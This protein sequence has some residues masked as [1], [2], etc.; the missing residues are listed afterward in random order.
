MW[1][2][3]TWRMK[4]KVL[5]MAWM[6]KY[7]HCVG[8]MPRS[9]A[10]RLAVVTEAIEGGQSRRMNSCAR[11]EVAMACFRTA[12]YCGRVATSW[13]AASIPAPEG[14][15]SSP[16]TA[17]CWLRAASDA[18]PSSRSAA[19]L[20]IWRGDS[21]RPAVRLAEGSRS[22]NRVGCPCA[23]SAAPSAET[24]VVLATPPFWLQTAIT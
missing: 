5:L 17:V 4:L 21:P 13:A 3:R 16:G 14:M 23:A 10:V 7:S 24:V 15:S 12:S 20:R 22:I 9:A 11:G 8:M 2:A 1:R 6:A 18:F 19:V